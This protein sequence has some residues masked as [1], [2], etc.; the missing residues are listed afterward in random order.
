MSKSSFEGLC[1]PK[2]NAGK[3]NFGNVI[4]S[5][6]LAP[7]K[8]SGESYINEIGTMPNNSGDV[9]AV[10]SHRSGTSI[11]VVPALGYTNGSSDAS[12]ITDADFIAGNILTGIDIFGLTGTFAVSKYARVSLSSPALGDS[13][14]GTGTY[15]SLTFTPTFVIGINSSGGSDTIFANMN[16]FNGSPASSKNTDLTTGAGTFRFSVYIGANGFTYTFYNRTG[17]SQSSGY[18]T[19]YV[20]CFA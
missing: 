18:Q 6:V 10:S 8:F 16:A 3:T 12:V 9:A 13:S 15:N 17:S 5:H 7:D 1:I 14:N 19:V 11:H 4:P 20:Y 2:P